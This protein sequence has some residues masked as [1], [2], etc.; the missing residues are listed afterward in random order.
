M[1]E[2][3]SESRS[4]YLSEGWSEGWSDD[5]SEGLS[6]GLSKGLSESCIEVWS[7]G[8]SE[9]WVVVNVCCRNCVDQLP[10]LKI[11]QRIIYQFSLQESIMNNYALHQIE[12]T[13]L[14]FS[15]A[16]I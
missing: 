8:W 5:L 1:S 7:E 9:G 3:L 16:R 6:E 2:G 4:E 15:I 10:S 12:Y 11:K 13:L 14:G